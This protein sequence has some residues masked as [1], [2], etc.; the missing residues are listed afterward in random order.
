M[1]PDDLARAAFEPFPGKYN[2]SEGVNGGY[3]NGCF[4]HCLS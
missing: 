4:I 2:R 1:N 3:F